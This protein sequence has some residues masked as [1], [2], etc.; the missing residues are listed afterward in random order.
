RRLWPLAAGPPALH[1]I[2]AFQSLTLAI[3]KFLRFTTL[4]SGPT[5]DQ[6]DS[7]QGLINLLL[8]STNRAG[9]CTWQRER[10]PKARLRQSARKSARRP[11]VRPRRHEISQ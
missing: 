4:G 11:A 5:S 1:T 9:G 10:K 6:A 3:A 2:W 8:L 7:A